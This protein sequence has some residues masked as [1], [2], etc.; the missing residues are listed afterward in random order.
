MSNRPLCQVVLEWLLPYPSKV[1]NG[2]CERFERLREKSKSEGSGS[3]IA[4]PDCVMGAGENRV[5]RSISQ[6]I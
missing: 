3:G 5:T 2:S 1:V 6:C 4:G